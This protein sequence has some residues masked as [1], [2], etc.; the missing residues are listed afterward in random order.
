MCFVGAAQL[1]MRAL[2]LSFHRLPCCTVLTGSYS[3]TNAHLCVRALCSI[4]SLPPGCTPPPPA[5]SDAANCAADSIQ[6]LA[7]AINGPAPIGSL[8]QAPGDHA[9]STGLPQ[10][11]SPPARTAAIGA[12]ALSAPVIA[13]GL[14]STAAEAASASAPAS[15]AKSGSLSLAG[16]LLV[17]R[18]AGGNGGVSDG[19]S[20]AA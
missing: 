18:R 9:C 15:P 6:A 16:L 14:G 8:G 17:D 20:R 5:A 1:R 4:P 19:G 13:A 3:T 11:A 10:A 12:S 2:Q 7:P